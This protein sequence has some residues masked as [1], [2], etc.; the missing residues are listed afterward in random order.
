MICPRCQGFV[1]MQFEETRC[2][3]CGWYDNPPYQECIRDPYD[4]IK[5]R[6]CANKAVPGKGLCEPC[7]EYQRTYHRTMKAAQRVRDRMKAL[8]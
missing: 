4:R 5:C 2:L 8:A 6:N 1:L 3:S 7:L